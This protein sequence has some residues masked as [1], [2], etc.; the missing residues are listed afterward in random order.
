MFVFKKSKCSQR[1]P[2]PQSMLQGAAEVKEAPVKKAPKIAGTK[3]AVKKK[4]VTEEPVVENN[5]LKK[6]E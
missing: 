2:V 3:P 6:E 4:T 1:K 5:E